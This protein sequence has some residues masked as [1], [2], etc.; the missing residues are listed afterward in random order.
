MGLANHAWATRLS[1]PLIDSAVESKVQ[2][3]HDGNVH[4]IT[5][6][7]DVTNAVSEGYYFVRI[8]NTGANNLRVTKNSDGTAGDLVSP[9]GSWEHAIVPGV[10]IYT[11]GTSGQGY[12]ATAFYP[13]AGQVGSSSF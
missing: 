1:N 3:F 10:K 6:A 2:T 11:I 12:N 13:T 7:A 5:V 4:D 8:S 9:G